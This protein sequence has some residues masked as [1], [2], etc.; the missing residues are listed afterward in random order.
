ME[1]EQDDR[2][3]WRDPTSK[4]VYVLNARTGCVVPEEPSRPHSDSSVALHRKY[5][6]VG[7]KM[8]LQRRRTG[9]ADSA[10]NAWL[11]GLLRTWENPVFKPVEQPIPQVTLDGHDAGT[12]HPK[13]SNHFHRSRID[14]DKVFSGAVMA[15]DNKMSKAGLQSAQVIAQLDRKFI[16]VKMLSSRERSS[17]EEEILV[18]I[19]QHAADERIRVEL[20]LTELCTPLL[21]TDRHY[22]SNLGHRSKVAFSVLEKPLQF[23]VSSQEG[24]LFRTQAASFGAWGILFDIICSKGGPA[25]AAAPEGDMLIISVTALPPSIS[26]RCKADPKLLISVLRSTIWK[27]AEAPLHN[28]H[29]TNEVLP[30]RAET[31]GNSP[32]WVRQLSSCP[33]GLVDLVNSRACRSAIMFNDELTINQCEELVVKLSR[34]VFPFMCAHGRPSM[35]PLVNL[36]DKALMHDAGLGLES[37]EAGDVGSGEDFVQAWKRWKPK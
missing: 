18:L 36:A 6:D 32:L 1:D 22:C 29:S 3:T 25:K 9:A 14:L 12:T 23:S 35:V 27:H 28:C 16:L 7:K 31:K 33:Q 4:H 10:K 30:P 15:S 34:C 26:E 11:N 37:S 2:I 21:D 19:D 13:L 5:K 8:R 24:Q 20:L 17:E